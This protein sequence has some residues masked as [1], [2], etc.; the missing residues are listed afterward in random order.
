MV[1]MPPLHQQ[2]ASAEASGNECSPLANLNKKCP[3]KEDLV[4]DL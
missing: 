1:V 4:K 3:L 2:N